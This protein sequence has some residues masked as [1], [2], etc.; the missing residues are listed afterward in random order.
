MMTGPSTTVINLPSAAAPRGGGG[1]GVGRRLPWLVAVVGIAV[2]VAAAWLARD[3]REHAVRE[4]LAAAANAEAGRLLARLLAAEDVLRSAAAHAAVADR[5]GEWTDYVDRL[6]LADHHPEMSRPVLQLQRAG[7]R[8]DTMPVDADRSSRGVSADLGGAL[9]ARVSAPVL[10]AGA[11]G[12]DDIVG[13]VESDVALKIGASGGAASQAAVQWTLDETSEAAV[14]AAVGRASL[15]GAIAVASLEHHGRRWWLAATPSPD[16]L[17]AVDAPDPDF[18]LA[19]GL[20]MSGGAVAALAVLRRRR[21]APVDGGEAVRLSPAPAEASAPD[22]QSVIDALPNPLFVKSDEGRWVAVNDAFCR[23]VGR[24]REALLD[25]TDADLLPAEH[26]ARN[27]EED[28]IVRGT[29]SG[30]TFEECLVGH[31]GSE[32]W[33]LK[34]KSPIRLA[35]GRTFLVGIA[36]DITERRRAETAAEG[37]RRLL[38]GVLDALPN[39]VSVKGADGRWVVVN[40]AAAR[41]LE[42]SAGDLLGRSAREFLDSFSAARSEREDDIVLGGESSPVREQLHHRNDGEARWFLTGKSPVS[43]PDGSPGIVE[44]STDITDRRRHEQ[45]VLASRHRLQL[46]NELTAGVVGGMRRTDIIRLAVDRLAAA[47]PG[48]RVT[49]AVALGDSLTAERVSG[50]ADLPVIEED[51][52]AV[53]D[54]VWETGIDTGLP[55]AIN[56]GTRDGAY[57]ALTAHL[58]A[59]GVSAVLEVAVRGEGGILGRIA[60]DRRVPHAWTNDERQTV[61]AV[62]DAVAVALGYLR[63]SADREAAL[64]AM[65]DQEDVLQAVIWA[66]DLGVWTWEVAAGRVQWSAEARRQL[67][68]EEDELADTWDAWKSRVH[69]DDLARVLAELQAALDAGADR[70]ESE[71]RVSHRDGHWI[72]ILSRARIRRDDQGAPERLLGGH[73]DV[74]EFRRVQEALRNHRDELERHVA[75]RTAELLAAK[76]GAEAANRAKTEFLANMSHELRTPMHAIL[77]FAQLGISRNGDPAK[78]RQYLDRIDTSGRRLLGLLNDLL[79]LSKL[80][81]GAMQYD[82]GSH[83]VRGMAAAAIQEFSALAGERRIAMVLDAEDLAAW[84]DPVRL[85]QVLRNLLSNAIR[86]T[87]VDGAVRLT[88]RSATVGEGSA[89]RPAVRVAVADNGVGIPEAEL[90][91]VFDKFVQS[92]KTTN[93]AGGT[94]LG[95]AICREIVARHRGT[96]RA[97]PT[98]GGGATIVMLLPREPLPHGSDSVHDK[99]SEIA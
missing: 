12:G 94:G 39:P 72:H 56:D 54:A 58:R 45:S 26:A 75:E 85:G 38:E 21:A 95:L 79:D 28:A 67:G 65:R 23:L 82:F 88:V 13:T 76:N 43:M 77:S 89:A 47:Q 97:E 49:F 14:R 57:P 74:T 22:F 96:I 34:S 61:I 3:H 78:T 30:R 29:G 98:A 48:A 90:E 50:G 36:T 99:R 32:R 68:F 10:R 6:H 83:S 51:R 62:A 1:A 15:H 46:V 64:Q 81:A 33:L 7:R 80:E 52:F 11:A 37:Q 59:A 16:F 86:F 70:F 44:W 18:V 55:M 17:R 8:G 53:R 93:G 35:D 4:R 24:T 19:T 66:T 63:A 69:P 42:R 92:S 60:L 31:D 73:L 41:H 84:C 91:T 2:T 71:F 5:D 27:R 87:P 25:R 20:C 9:R 40:Q